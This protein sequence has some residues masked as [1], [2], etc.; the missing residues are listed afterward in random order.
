MGASFDAK[1]RDWSIRL[2]LILRHV[3]FSSLPYLPQRTRFIQYR[4][5]SLI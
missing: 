5:I 4:G 1:L 2:R 3:L